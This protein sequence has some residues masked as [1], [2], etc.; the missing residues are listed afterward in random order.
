MGYINI[1]SISNRFFFSAHL[2]ASALG[3]AWPPKFLT[4]SASFHH[5][6]VV[7]QTARTWW[8]RSWRDAMHLYPPSVELNSQRFLGAD[9]NNGW[10]DPNGDLLGDPVS[11][12]DPDLG[13]PGSP[14]NGKTGRPL[15]KLPKNSTC[16]FFYFT[17]KIIGVLVNPLLGGW[18][19]RKTFQ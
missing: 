4:V 17:R 1:T 19:P 13:D 15:Y 3:F 8:H 14:W 5:V 18:D 2:V 12:G 6:V 11:C 16:F 7:L 10:E 9:V